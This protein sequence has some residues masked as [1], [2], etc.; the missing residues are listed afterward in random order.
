MM[1]FGYG[2]DGAQSDAASRLGGEKAVVR[3]H[4][5]IREAVVHGDV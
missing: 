1:L 5:D 4:G 2:T 3:R